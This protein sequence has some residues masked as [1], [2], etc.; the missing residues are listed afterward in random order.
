M[1]H[2]FVNIHTHRRTGEGIEMV[3]VTASGAAVV[4]CNA[5]EAAGATGAIG[6][7]EPAE[8]AAATESAGTANVAGTENAESINATLPDPPF[9][10]GIHPWQ[11][12]E[13]DLEAALRRIETAPAS[14]IG[15]TGLD[16]A[17]SPDH[18]LQEPVF[19]AQLRIAQRRHLPVVLHCVRAFEPVMDILAGFRLRAVIF[20]GFTG[21]HQQAARAVG[22]GYYLSLGERS[23]RSPKTTAALETIPLERLFLETDDAPVSI[24]EIYTRAA[25]AACTPLLQLKERLYNNYMAIFEI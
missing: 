15:E 14:A 17:R 21:S 12:A 10:I 4:R 25:E 23:L 8:T 2:P 22:A 9:S 6:A 20:H 18:T 11:S 24:A 7:T 5:L 13:C 19:V 3:S 16:Y 1:D